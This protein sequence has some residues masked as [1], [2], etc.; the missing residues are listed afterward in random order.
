MSLT[1]K[2][3]AVSASGSGTRVW[4]EK[5]QNEFVLYCFL[6][7]SCLIGSSALIFQE[8]R[9][10]HDVARFPHCQTV[11]CC[12]APVLDKPACSPVALTEE[13]SFQLLNLCQSARSSFFSSNLNSFLRNELEGRTAAV[14]LPVILRM[15]ETEMEKRKHEVGLAAKSAE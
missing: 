9:K 14:S 6:F 2:Y 4:A 13:A 15:K 5:Y 7:L 12:T 1:A 3:M 11:P 10:D 8:A